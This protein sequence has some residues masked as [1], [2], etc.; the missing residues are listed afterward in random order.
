MLPAVSMAEVSAQSNEIVKSVVFDKE[1]DKALYFLEELGI[2]TNFKDSETVTRGQF[3]SL[4]VNLAYNEDHNAEDEKIF[5]DVT[6]ECEYLSDI[7]FAYN[8]GIVS[9]NNTFRPYDDITYSE[10]ITMATVALGYS[11]VAQNNGGYPY[12]YTKC[13]SDIGLSDN[14]SRAVTDKLSGSDVLFLLY[15]MLDIEFMTANLSGNSLSYS[16]QAGSTILT[17]RYDLKKVEGKVTSTAYS[18]LSGVSTVSDNQ[19]KID[20]VTFKYEGDA[21]DLL[22]MKVVAYIDDDNKA[23]IVCPVYN[24]ILEADKAEDYDPTLFRLKLEDGNTTE[25]VKLDSSFCF[26]YNGVAYPSYAKT[27][28]TDINGS[29]KLVDNDGDGLYDIAFV[30]DVEYMKVS[31]VIAVDKVIYGKSVSR[32]SISFNE[33]LHIRFYKKDDT[34]VEISPLDIVKDNILALTISKDGKVGKATVI[35]NEFSGKIEQVDT[36]Y[37]RIDGYD[38]KRSSYLDTYYTPTVGANATF[39]LGLLD[40]IVLYELEEIRGYRY[41]YLMNV[42]QKRRDETFELTIFT[43]D[44]EVEKFKCAEKVLIDGKRITLYKAW[45]NSA[46][47]L[48][49]ESNVTKRQL[50]KYKLNEGLIT[51]IDT[52]SDAALTDSRLKR[53]TNNSNDCLLR[54]YD[55]INTHYKSDGNM[56]TFLRFYINSQTKIFTVPKWTVTTVEDADFTLM[57]MSMLKNDNTYIVDAYDLDENGVPQVILIYSDDV[58]NLNQSSDYGVVEKVVSVWN[59]DIGVCQAISIWL[60]GKCTVY[61][62]EDE[63]KS[64]AIKPGTGKQ[65]STGDLVRFVHKNGVIRELTVDF[66]ADTMS[67]SASAKSD[68]VKGDAAYNSK[69]SYIL[70][71]VYHRTDTH[72]IVSWTKSGG[73]WDYSLDS[74]RSIPLRT[75]NSS[76]GIILI[77]NNKV[78]GIYP[79]EVLDYCSAGNAADRILLIQGY[80]Q[81]ANIVIYR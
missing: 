66:D 34:E 44:G 25:T 63:N 79:N 21:F 61:Y 18:D 16:V 58:S 37:I 81:A 52:V 38:Y 40:D 22:G 45:A 36:D 13:A 48:T 31:Q 9:K 56:Y 1:A 72:Y 15:N 77:E 70:A 46:V 4:I 60:N 30:Y 39:V 73:V 5:D 3:T 41:G 19:I 75:G 32:D 62:L 74:L 24:Q 80:W 78:R 54:Y 47:P 76:T 67:F 55:R 35:N 65:I 14:I 29:I 8:R 43:D 49:D 68:F 57:D 23:L 51:A 6:D 11:F 20:G 42:R 50:I 2:E 69:R 71:S 27:D 64:L 53:I 7:Y 17:D 26:I 28:F 12:G 33:D 59:E 10:A